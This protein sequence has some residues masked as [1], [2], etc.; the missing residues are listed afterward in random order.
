MSKQDELRELLK[1]V[2]DQ[3]QDFV[4][5]MMSYAKHYDIVTELKDFLLTHEHATTDDIIE[6]ADELI[7]G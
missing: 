7:D 1:K 4:V 6:Y 2:P 3:Y 5:C